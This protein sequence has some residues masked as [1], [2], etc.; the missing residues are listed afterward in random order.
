LG[1]DSP[2]EWDTIF[3]V[4]EQ[5][6][7]SLSEA[8]FARLVNSALKSYASLL[9]LSRSPLAVSPLIGPAL[10]LDEAAPTAD[11][12]GRALRVVLRWAVSR[13]APSPPRYPLGAPRPFDDPTW[14][15]PLW[16]RYNILR[17]RYIEP[18]HP[19]ELEECGH[20]AKLLE[21]T[22]IPGDDRLFDER[23]RAIR[24][25]SL[26]LREQI[27]NPQCGAELRRMAVED[28]VHE[29]PRPARALLDVAATFRWMFPRALLIEMATAEHLAE[30]G[31][32]LDYVVAQRLLLAD[33]GG[34]NL[35]MPPALQEYIRSC[36][37]G[38][39]PNRRHQRA[40]QFYIGQ[41][42][43]IQ[44]AW[45]LQMAEQSVQA[46]DLLLG[47]ADAL[48]TEGRIEELREALAGFVEEQLS[49]D[50][51]RAVQLVLGDLCQRV[52]YRDGAL[53]AYRRALRVI[54]EP[55]Q[56]ARIFRRLGKLY[57]DDN[58]IRALGYYQHAAEQLEPG[59]PEWLDLLKDRG[60]LRIIRCEWTE[61]EADLLLALNM[62]EELAVE[63]A[64]PTAQRQRADVYSALA[65][66]YRRQLQYDRAITC[67]QQALSLREETGDLQRVAEACGNL[68]LI[69]NKMGEHQQAIRAYEE[70]LATFGKI[71]DREGIANAHNNIG[72]ALYY[73]G[74]YLE[75]IE[76][77]QE[78]LAIF[79]EIGLPRGEAQAHQNLAE[80]FAAL[81]QIEEARWHWRE[82]YTL[83]Q[84]AGLDDQLAEFR[85]LRDR[86]PVLQG[87]DA[88][89]DASPV[90]A[91]TAVPS[92]STP[93]NLLPVERM[94]LEIARQRGRVT[95]HV[96]ME[97]ANV[98]KSRATRCL[99]D[100]AERGMLIRVGKG[101]ASHCVIP[102]PF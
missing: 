44:A 77:Y 3:S 2:V 33:D 22:G 82:G 81:G 98:S 54:A 73:C 48:I 79:R 31:A 63:K 66:L 94:A 97:Q 88:A 49:P 70:A 38:A 13:L 92:S 99:S 47:V 52:G 42:H 25:V 32:A 80:A 7:L 35:L 51:W 24:D 37:S 30:V 17:H 89:S 21:L 41:H 12:R 85:G 19:D 95:T 5:S 72:A 86:T 69:Y 62:V 36:Q 60:W 102:S 100:L 16:W 96:L 67:A 14:L 83:S 68:G 23:N 61:A 43:P 76:R 1:L 58:Q 45:H 56:Q 34:V 28:Y 74:R 64:L 40:A 9:E 90:I 50:R 46:A 55:A 87:P 18:I 20:I 39:N 27:R 65:S 57:E 59:D 53:T 15:D 11:D 71:G 75:A 4:E 101:R 84:E 6:L 93:A 26:L 29:A 91:N 78:G 8:D 10:V